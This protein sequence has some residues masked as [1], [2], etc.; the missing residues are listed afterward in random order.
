M[1]N[2]ILWI[3]II[4]YSNKKSEFFQIFKFEINLDQI[5]VKNC[6]DGKTNNFNKFC[7]GSLHAPE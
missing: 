6:E 3:R 7:S 2:R 4:Q 5:S 1:E